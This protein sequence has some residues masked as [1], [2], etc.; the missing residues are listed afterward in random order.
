MLPELLAVIIHKR[1]AT[2]ARAPVRIVLLPGLGLHAALGEEVEMNLHKLF[3]YR[4]CLTQE[5]INL[6]LLL[7]LGT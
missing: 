1:W 7:L 2:E 5:I 3:Q 6:A 4:L